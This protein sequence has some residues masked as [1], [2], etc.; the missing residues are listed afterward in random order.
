[1]K[2]HKGQRD[3][4]IFDVPNELDDFVDG[5]GDDIPDYDP[6]DKPDSFLEMVKYY[7]WLI[8]F[9]LIGVPY[10]LFVIAANVW[11][12]W[13]NAQLNDWWAD[14]NLYL[15]L[16]TYFGI[17]QSIDIVFLVFELPVYLKAMKDA[18]ALSYGGAVLY[19]VFYL[20]IAS[21]FVYTVFFG[22]KKDGAFDVFD[23]L[24]IMFYGYNI[25]LHGPIAVMNGVT[26]LKEI[27]LEFT[28]L[29][30]D[31]L[32]LALNTTDLENGVVDLTWFLNPLS[33]LDVFWEYE[34]DE[35]FEDEY[36]N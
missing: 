6:D 4:W 3:E 31:D 15:L 19:N 11:N 23:L 9:W 12:I 35:D 21:E 34:Y 18:R 2:E 10:L 7:R 20:W 1:M 33:W 28:A 8:N 24:K 5:F 27:M 29:I 17:W 30:T 26:I 32:D 36:W 22:G 25:V 14:G 13:F 16:N